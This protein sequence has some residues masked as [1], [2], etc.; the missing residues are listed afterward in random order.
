MQ[1]KLSDGITIDLEEGLLTVEDDTTFEVLT[2]VISSDWLEK[3][4]LFNGMTVRLTREVNGTV[5][6][7]ETKLIYSNV[8]IGT[9]QYYFLDGLNPTVNSVVNDTTGTV[10]YIIEHDTATKSVKFY[11][12]EGTGERSITNLETFKN[13]MV[14]GD[15][16]ETHNGY[17]RDKQSQT[18]AFG[19]N[20]HADYSIQHLYNTRNLASD[21]FV[22]TNFLGTGYKVTIKYEDYG[23]HYYY[24]GTELDV[25]DTVFG[26][27]IVNS[28]LPKL[29]NVFWSESYATEVQTSVQV[30]D[31]EIWLKCNR[32]G[33]FFG[34]TEPTYSVKNV[35]YTWHTYE[36]QAKSKTVSFQYFKLAEVSTSISNESEYSG[37]RYTT[38]SGQYIYEVTENGQTVY[39]DEDGNRVYLY[40]E[41]TNHVD[42]QGCSALLKNGVAYKFSESDNGQG[43]FETLEGSVVYTDSNGAKYYRY[44]VLQSDGTIEY[45]TYDFVSGDTTVKY[46]LYVKVDGDNISLVTQKQLDE[47]IVS[48]GEKEIY[49]TASNDTTTRL[50]KSTGEDT[51]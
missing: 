21:E 17:Y 47:T 18:S 40:D 2:Q 12:V 3:V 49:Y 14:K 44:G 41:I 35:K 46:L 31:T 23:F 29:N 19:G 13:L 28:T 25:E 10:Y 37:I 16:V 8:F 15:K 50:N 43:C 7:W 26:K 32:P 22:D 36:F 42:S 5:Q 48:E 27:T 38:A 9:K 20:G 33:D 30:A 4:N 11:Q 39:Q 34:F 45:N 24:N 51:M 6:E 1:I